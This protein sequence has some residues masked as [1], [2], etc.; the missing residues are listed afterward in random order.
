[1]PR[2]VKSNRSYDSSKRR[3]DAAARRQAVLTS[4]GEL[5]LQHGFAATTVAAVADRADVSPET[6]YKY[7][8]GKPGLVRALHEQAILGEGPVPAEHR[9]NSLRT[10]ADALEVIRG[11]ARLTREVSP[12]VAPILLLVRDAALVD[13]DMGELLSELD[14]ARHRRMTDNAKFLYAAG[15]LRPGLTVQVAADLLWSVSA[16]EMFE[17]LVRRRRWSLE[18]YADFIYRTIA[19]GLLATA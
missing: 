9:S 12:R 7:F 3:A 1:M 2:D 6:V 10:H 8:G 17:L 5:F 16:P 19:H 13:T 14:D 11:W 4:A 18:M 15:H